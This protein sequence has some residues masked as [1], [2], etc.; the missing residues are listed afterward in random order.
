[1]TKLLEKLV[2]VY[3][4]KKSDMNTS[5]KNWWAACILVLSF[6]FVIVLGFWIFVDKFT[7]TEV[8]LLPLFVVYG[9]GALLASL[10]V[11]TVT[12]NALNLSDPKG[13]LGLPEGSVRAVIALS[14]IIIFMIT[15]IFLYQHIAYP[16][17]ASWVLTAN[18]ANATVNN[19]EIFTEIYTEQVKFAQQ[20]LTTVSTLVVAVAGFYFGTRSV[21]AAHGIREKP[22][23][24]L[25]IV[26]PDSTVVKLDKAKDTELAIEVEAKGGAVSWETPPQ[27]DTDGK[28]VQVK[29]GK[30][31]YTPGSKAEPNVILKFSLVDHP[32]VNDKLVVQ[33]L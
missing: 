19:T 20:I 33:T 26:T 25:R 17:I 14:L 32:E 31:T 10:A 6:L 12:L 27:G 24:G 16:T 1:M 29:P 18:A 30:F 8:L 23:L 11:V 9:V 7:Y 21:E 3:R 13:A 22:S 15:A 28:I 2:E 4:A 5:K